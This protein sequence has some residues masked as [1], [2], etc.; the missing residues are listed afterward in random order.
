MVERWM[1]NEL[2]G[3]WKEADIAN[4]TVLSRY[5]RGGAEVKNENPQSG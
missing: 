2:E 5:F 3:I 1:D 4:F